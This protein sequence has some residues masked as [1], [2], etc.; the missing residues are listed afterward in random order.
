MIKSYELSII[1][2]IYNDFEILKRTIGSTISMKPLEIIIIDN[3]PE[4]NDVTLLPEWESLKYF[5]TGEN[6]GYAGGA[7]F[8][9][10]LIS[11][12]SKWVTIMNADAFFEADYYMKINK[13]IGNIPSNDT[14]GAIG[15]K[16]LKYDFEKM[17]KT[18]IIDSAG[19][20]IFPSG[21]A[22]DRGQHE[23]DTGQYN[24]N[25]IADGICGALVS[26]NVDIIKKVN[27]GSYIFD[28]KFHAY[29]EDIDIAISLKKNGYDSFYVGD[30]VAFHGR[31]MGKIKKWPI[32]SYLKE[33]KKQSPYLK[34]LS[35]SNHWYMIFK[36]RDFIFKDQLSIYKFSIR[37]MSEII[38]LLFLDY[39]ILKKSFLRFLELV[40]SR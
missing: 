22:I 36:H 10:K 16:L 6:L 26:Y 5:H 38:F 39:K 20:K 2:V 24:K 18:L 4:V 30:V 32:N 17:K 23:K 13:N 34:V 21:R 35:R 33:V 15:S 3:S 12:N 29:K 40:N 9:F 37:T 28:N 25:E 1:Y 27:N 8:G 11:H 19:I 31:G 14:I 7:N